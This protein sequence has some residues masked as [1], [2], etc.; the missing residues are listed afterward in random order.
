MKLDEART[1]ERIIFFVM[2]ALLATIAY[3][4]GD[5]TASSIAQDDTDDLKVFKNVHIE[6]SLTVGEVINMGP[7][8]KMKPSDSPFQR[9]DNL[10]KK[11][12][13]MDDFLKTFSTPAGGYPYMSLRVNEEDAS[14]FMGSGTVHTENENNILIKVSKSDPDGFD[15]PY[16]KVSKEPFSKTF[17]VK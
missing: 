7:I 14:I 12:E 6:K 1:K 9:L 16:I 4:A 17:G 5:M 10:D 13:K 15:Y 8:Q 11:L 2:G 3:V